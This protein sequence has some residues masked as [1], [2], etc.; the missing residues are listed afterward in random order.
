VR[1]APAAPLPVIVN[2]AGGSASRAGDSLRESIQTAFAAAGQSIALEL[3]HGEDLPAALD[4]HNAGQRVAVG[5]GDGTLAAGAAAALR[6]GSE[7]AILPLGT[8]NHFA[9]QL[10][11]PLEIEEA[12]RLA[13]TGT[14]RRIDIG[15]AGDRVF[16]NNLSAGAYVELVREREA[17]R[18]PKLLATIPATWHTLR[19]LRSRRFELTIDGEL[20]PVR[21]PLLFVGNNRYQVEEGRPAERATLNDGMLSIYAVAPLSRAALVA[22]ALRT[23]AGKARMRRDFCLDAEAREVRIEGPGNAIEVALDGERVRFDLPLTIRIR[24]RVLAV[25]AP[26][27]D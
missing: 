7:L 10:G 1:A 14:A 15:E 27:S 9:R 26:E 21:T 18:L 5:G 16:I 2:A 20:H 23:L 24:P 8:R 4:G 12:V 13:A 17:S 3:V 11:I 25:V 19:K 6:N 22:A